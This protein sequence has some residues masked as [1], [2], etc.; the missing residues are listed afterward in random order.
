MNLLRLNW[1]NFLY[2][3][4]SFLGETRLDT[5]QKV[6]AVPRYSHDTVFH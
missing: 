2:S 6:M 5:H 4:N 3:Y 1:E